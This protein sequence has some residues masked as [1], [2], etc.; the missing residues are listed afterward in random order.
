MSTIHDPDEAVNRHTHL[1]RLLD[2]IDHGRLGLT[3]VA[4]RTP[5]GQEAVG[6]FDDE[7]ALLAAV[8]ANVD[9]VVSIGLQPRPRAL[10]E[11]APN[12]L[13]IGV[14]AA[15]AEEIT[16]VTVIGVQVDPA[17]AVQSVLDARFA[18][19]DPLVATHDARGLI[20]RAIAPVDVTEASRP[21]I[22]ERLRQCHAALS[23]AGLPER[24]QLIGGLA[25]HVEVTRLLVHNAPADRDEQTAV[26]RFLTSPITVTVGLTQSERAQMEARLRQRDA[27]PSEQVRLLFELQ[28]E[29]DREHPESRNGGS[30]RHRARGSAPRFAEYAST[31]LGVSER[32]IYRLLRISTASA[33]VLAAL[34]AGSISTT[35]AARV[36]ESVPG[37]QQD[38]LLAVL[39]SKTIARSR[40]NQFL[41]DAREANAACSRAIAT[42]RDLDE[43][44]AERLA[45]AARPLRNV[46][47]DQIEAVEVAARDS[48]RARLATDDSSDGGLTKP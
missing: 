40:H 35:D 42:A 21:V 5:D 43:V 15:A 32:S 19:A 28:R 23:A 12:Q 45:A 3:E 22:E 8:E 4:V 26:S 48:K 46:L 44:S 37:E 2:Y 13:M 10:L 24:V 18:A 30:G 11:R 34:D 36:A 27:R 20:V 31:L 6:Y 38:E 17:T 47:A 29:Y 25:S 16:H 1:R 41:A 9:G 7:E 14:A 39:A 33:A